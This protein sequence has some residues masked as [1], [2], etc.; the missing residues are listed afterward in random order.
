MASTSKLGVVD[1]NLL[2]ATLRY[3]V[4]SDDNS[5]TQNVSQTFLTQDVSLA[6][7]F[8]N[9]ANRMYF[10]SGDDGAGQTVTTNF[11]YVDAA[12][13]FTFSNFV[14]RDQ[15]V[16]I[17][18]YI[19]FTTRG[20]ADTSNVMF[21]SQ[22]SL[23]ASRA[24]LVFQNDVTQTFSWNDHDGGDAAKRTF[25]ASNAFSFTETVQPLEL[26]DVYQQ[27]FDTDPI[28]IDTVGTDFGGDTAQTFL[29]QHVTFRIQGAACPE[30]E[31]TPFIGVSGDD[32]FPEVSTGPPTLG[33]GV[34]TLT[35]PRVSPTLT[36]VLKNPEFGNKDVLRFTKID[37]TTRGGERK[38]FSDLGWG[39][40]Q[41]FELKINNLCET[42]VTIDELLDFLNTSLGEEVG[43][44]DWENRQW[45][46]IIVVPETDVT[47]TVGGH[48]I[49]IVFEGEL[50]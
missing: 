26:E 39:S 29:R 14:G 34:L 5:F 30:K 24:G 44:L 15:Q 46:G 17:Q 1:S 19:G 11:V 6:A 22:A 4:Q 7:L 28:T 48:S 16:D 36:L 27:V 42:N 37:R 35:H 45:K 10:G 49:R 47:P 9:T 23:A 25:N 43:L 18:Q 33:S 31:Y 20:F 50:A 32:S 21:N 38:I 8:A 13:E 40:T 12:N 2:G 41:S 3:G